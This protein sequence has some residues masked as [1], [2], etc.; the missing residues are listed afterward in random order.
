MR[1]YILYLFLCYCYS[2]HPDF[3]KETATIIDSRF[4][5]QINACYDSDTNVRQIVYLPTIE[6][7]K[8]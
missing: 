4:N 1:F 7:V 2:H 8:V 6:G 3:F 5:S